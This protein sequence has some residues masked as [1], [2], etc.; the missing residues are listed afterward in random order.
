MLKMTMKQT[1]DS[2]QSFDLYNDCH[3]TENNHNPFVPPTKLELDSYSI[4]SIGYGAQ[5]DGCNC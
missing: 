1:I 4:A 2:K 3:S 5:D